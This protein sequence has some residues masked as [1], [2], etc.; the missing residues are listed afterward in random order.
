MWRLS[1]QL[2]TFSFENIQNHP[3]NDENLHRRRRRNMIG[4]MK[5]SVKKK[6]ICHE[7]HHLYIT[8]CLEAIGIIYFRFT[9]LSSQTV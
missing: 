5:K 6:I 3:E 2:K 9:T 8:P 1:L 4:C 7:N